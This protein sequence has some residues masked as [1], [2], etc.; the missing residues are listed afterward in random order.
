MSS[1]QMDS[2]GKKKK[3]R[4]RKKIEYL[5]IQDQIARITLD[6]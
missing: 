1:S 3:G 2:A 5:Q 4:K 6:F